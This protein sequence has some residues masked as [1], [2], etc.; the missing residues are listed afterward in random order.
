MKRNI[1]LSVTVLAVLLTLTP[2]F[3]REQSSGRQ[4][5]RHHATVTGAPAAHAGELRES[6]HQESGDDRGGRAEP[7]DD[8]GH[9]GGG[10]R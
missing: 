3:A 2:A 4:G 5:A 6:R 1:V 7:S 10:H 9:H 8:H